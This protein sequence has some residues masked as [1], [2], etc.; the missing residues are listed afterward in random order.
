ME[1]EIR[2]LEA[3][4]NIM[5]AEIPNRPSG[6]ARLNLCRAKKSAERTVGKLVARKQVEIQLPR[7]EN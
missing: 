5:V 2:D 1:N 3:K 4:K 6:S 7:V